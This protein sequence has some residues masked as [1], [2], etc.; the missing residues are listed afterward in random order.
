MAERKGSG[1]LELTSWRARRSPTTWR[2]LLREPD[3]DVA[4]RF[5]LSTSRGRPLATDSYL[6]KLEPLLGRRLRPLPDGRPKKKRS[7]A[8]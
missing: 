1:L 8:G 5:R 6:S 4:G 2:E 7:K 3:D